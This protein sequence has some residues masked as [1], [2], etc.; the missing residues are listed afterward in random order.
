MLKKVG[1][2]V[3]KHKT[4]IVVI[5]ALAI[6]AAAYHQYSSSNHD[7]VDENEKKD[8]IIENKSKRLDLQQRSKLSLKANKQ[9]D[10]LVGPLL[11]TLRSRVTEELDIA[12]IVRTI[13]E[14]RLK[15]KDSNEIELWEEIKILSFSMI[16]VNSIMMSIFVGVLRLQIYLVARLAQ[17]MNIEA[18]EVIFSSIL[19]RTYE[20]SLHDG[21][22]NAIK[23]VRAIVEKFFAE[24]TIQKK[25]TVD[26]A[27][28]ESI[29]NSIRCELESQMT[30]IIHSILSGLY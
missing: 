23:T 22:L 30:D 18:N 11:M 29:V 21:L 24:W 12:S 13:K 9:F 27:E 28:F 19:E 17:N 3:W 5:S 6:A 8:T 2:F 10:S 7:E 4:K 25:L 15:L 26:Y 16:F 1:D 20:Y 14:I